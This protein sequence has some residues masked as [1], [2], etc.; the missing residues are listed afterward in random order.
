MKKDA[1][2]EIQFVN[3]YDQLVDQKVDYDWLPV[4]CG[5]CR[6]FGHGEEDCRK[7]QVNWEPKP[8]GLDPKIINRDLS[9]VSH[10]PSGTAIVSSSKGEEPW[11]TP[12]KTRKEGQKLGVTP[13]LKLKNVAIVNTVSNG[14]PPNLERQRAQQGS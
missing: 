14:G 3:E 8:I 2:T 7:K 10:N 12:R 1:I 4:K 9:P 13:D 6:G 5:C 11:I